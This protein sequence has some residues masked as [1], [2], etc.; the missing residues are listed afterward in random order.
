[1]ADHLV[2]TSLPVPEPRQARPARLAWLAW[3]PGP[4]LIGAEVLKLTRRRGLMIAAILLTTGAVLA[5]FAVTGALHASSPLRYGPAGGVSGL[6]HSVYVL[7]QLA[8]VTA[9]LIGAAAGAG[10]LSA[11]VF[12]N[13]VSTGQSRVALFL[14]RIPAGL[15]VAVLVSGAA[16]AASAVCSVLLAGSLPAPPVHLM[17]AAGGW[18]ML[19]VVMAYLL[20]LGLSSLIGSQSTT[21]AVL[22]AVTLVVTPLAA[23]VPPLPDVRQLLPG[24]A[25]YQVEPQALGPIGAGALTMTSAAIAAVLGAWAV[26]A[27][28]VGAWRT[29][30]RDA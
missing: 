6:H 27:V 21:V 18:L 12:R 1:M 9:I 28:A 17:A 24:V 5:L 2:D 3:V 30:T 7:Q 29:A 13:L 23:S 26:A 16:Y 25:L 11:G 22:V 19:D 4:R 10:D 14:A 20:A 15:G 8:A